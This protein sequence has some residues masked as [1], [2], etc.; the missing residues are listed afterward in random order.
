G[1]ETNSV[2]KFVSNFLGGSGLGSIVSEIAG[3]FGG[4]TP[5][6]PL[7]LYQ[8]ALPRSVSVEAGV[9]RNGQFAPVSHSQNGT[10]RADATPQPA[11]PT[12]AQPLT[13]DS[14]WFMDHSEDIA[15]AVKE[16]MLHSHS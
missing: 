9:T 11:V 7:P 5:E 2:V 15:S 16:A 1:G 13:V 8:F 10:V 3:L 6:E 12:A 4:G 14:R